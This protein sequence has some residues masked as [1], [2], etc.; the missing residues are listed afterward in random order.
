MENEKKNDSENPQVML[1][2]L[3]MVCVTIIAVSYF[4]WG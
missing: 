3:A 4:I 2:A 1:A